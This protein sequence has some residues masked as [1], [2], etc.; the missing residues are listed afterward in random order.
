[1]TKEPDIN[2]QLKKEAW[3]ILKQNQKT[4]EKVSFTYPSPGIYS[5]QWFWDSCF[6]AI[7]LTNFNP[8]L[9][10]AEILSLLSAQQPDGFLPHIIF[11]KK[12]LLFG[13]YK[14]Y[15][16][17]DIFYSGFDFRKLPAA[18]LGLAI[19]YPSCYFESK[20]SF[21]PN[22]TALIQPPVLAQ[23]VEKIWNKTGDKK[24]LE[25][26]LPKVKLYYQWLSQNRDPD[27]DHLISIISPFES[28]LDYNP[29]YDVVFNIKKA[30]TLNLI[31]K[32]RTLSIRNYLY[33]YN[34]EKIFSKDFFNVEDVLVNSIY[35]QGLK[36]LS[37]LCQDMG[38]NAPASFFNEISQKVTQA[39]I[40][41]CYEPNLAAFYNLYSKQEKMAKVLTISSL[42]PIILDIDKSIV[43]QIL[44]RHILNPEEFWLPYPL[45]SVAKNESSFHPESVL[46]DGGRFIW[47]GSTWI[48]TNW[49][50]VKALQKHGLNTVAQ[51]IIEKTKQLI[52]KSGFR[53]YYN[54]LTGEGGGARNFSWSTL[55]VDLLE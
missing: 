16:K 23:A 43:N 14:D 8:D 11:W 3:K 35:A 48:N 52:L 32:T 36:S 5:Y 31:Y 4:L 44:N 40:N 15:L 41:K 55:I 29:S 39:L 47:R 53:E 51:K 30:N 6:H 25:T 27:R 20:P 2:N 13:L 7:V 42:F 18:I 54:P 9:A 33:S 17:N 34:L 24:F 26:V 21:C 50:I 46:S 28:G 19:V 12:K 45:P 38:E 22:H 1:M 10:K 37:R 49:F